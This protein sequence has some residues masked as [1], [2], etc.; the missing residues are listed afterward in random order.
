MVGLGWGKRSRSD[1]GALSPTLGTGGSLLGFD[2]FEA[3]GLLIWS[4]M[5]TGLCCLVLFG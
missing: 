2:S 3:A 4:D 1:T 5:L